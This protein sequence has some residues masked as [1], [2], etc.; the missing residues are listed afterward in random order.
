[1]G[2]QSLF[3]CST[4][5]SIAL[6]RA[7]TELNVPHRI[8]FRVMTGVPDL[9]LIHPR[10]AGGSEVE[11]D[12]PPLLG[13]PFLGVLRQMHRSIVQDDMDLLAIVGCDDLLHQPQKIRRRVRLG[14]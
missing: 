10:R 4:N 9:D 11:N 5:D 6:L 1:M 12:S 14:Q 3:Q 2:A 7:F 13:K 8:S